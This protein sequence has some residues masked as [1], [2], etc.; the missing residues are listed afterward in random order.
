MVYFDKSA[1]SLARGQGMLPRPTNG[2]PPHQKALWYVVA[3]EELEQILHENLVVDA[4][5]QDVL[6]LTG[7]R[8]PECISIVT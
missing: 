3:R 1:V 4:A 7:R 8:F 2:A 6:R 5:T